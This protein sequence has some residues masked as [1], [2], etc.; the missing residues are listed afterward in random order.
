MINA[1]ILLGDS[2]PSVDELKSI[3]KRILSY[4]R[5][6][7]TPTKDPSTGAWEF[8]PPVHS[9][10]RDEDLDKHLTFIDNPSS[11]DE[12]AEAG[13]WS[14]VN[15]V[16]MKPLL[17]PDPACDPWWEL[18]VIRNTSNP[19]TSKIKKATAATAAAKKGTG[20][21]AAGEGASG[22]GGGNSCCVLLRVHHTIGDGIA[23]VGMISEMLTTVEG[24]PL[25]GA[26]FGSSP[27]AKKS[28]KGLSSRA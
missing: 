22:S 20:G 8:K 12:D 13:L 16:A 19:A 6:A 2:N 7:G 10:P 25:T 14:V 4:D 11:N 23:L 3:I 5:F 1:A 17:K 26:G 18:V 24:K 27:A 15:E 9:P 28:A 21:G